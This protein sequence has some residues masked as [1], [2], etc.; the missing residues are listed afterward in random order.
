MNIKVTSNLAKKEIAKNLNNTKSKIIIFGKDSLKK[1]LSLIGHQATAWEL[2]EAK[3]EKKSLLIGKSGTIRLIQINPK[4]S[5][6]HHG[7]FNES[8]Y[9]C[10]REK[11][12]QIVSNLVSEKSKEISFEF[13][14]LSDE[15]IIGSIV[16]LELALYRFTNSVKLGEI[17]F[18]NNGKKIDNKLISNAKNIAIAINQARH[19]VNLPPNELNPVSY[20]DGIKEMFNGSKK[21]SVNILDEKKLAKE[22]CNLILSVG[23]SSNKPP[24]IV[25]LSY[26]G[27]DKKKSPI[28][29]I[30][31][32]VTF[33]TGGT[34]I[35][36]AAGMRLM[37]KDMGGSATLVGF[38]RWLEN[39]NVKENIDIYLALAENSVSDKASRPSDIIK[40]RAGMT[41]E[42]DNTDAEGRLVMASAMSLALDKKPSMMFDV[43]TLTGAG[44]VALGQD[45]N[46]LF[47]NDD[48]MSEKL[49]KAAQVYGDPA[50]RMPLY[51]PYVK[52]LASDFADMTNCGSSWGGAITA[53]LFLE[54]FV[55][56]T[57][58][59]HFDIYGWTTGSRPELVQKGGNAQGVETLIG[60]F[61]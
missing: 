42:I 16:G 45:V 31:K 41:V 57:K 4:V 24:R 13:L 61:S 28:A 30:G 51:S 58:W 5:N 22:N 35:K 56:N 43:A 20:A 49:L 11:I 32:G 12:G 3:E 50:W 21:I 34:D 37:K 18:K 36:P 54:K 46:S 26:Q 60:F 1:A 48:E 38:A 19:L 23:N 29:M 7:I 2:K 14:N 47:C 39:S 59:A 55:G 8:D 27:A 52:Q 15:A 9:S 17:S 10:A 53:A 25:V 44:K 6:S 40:S 33:D